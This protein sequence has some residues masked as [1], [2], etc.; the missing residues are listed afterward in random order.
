MTAIG[1]YKEIKPGTLRSLRSAI[2]RAKKRGDLDAVISICDRA[3]AVFVCAGRF[4]EANE[5]MRARDAA[6][7]E[8]RGER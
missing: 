1:N 3:H 7:L 4:D 6:A 5:F 2:T 8:M